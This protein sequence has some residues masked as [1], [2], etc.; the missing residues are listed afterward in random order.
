MYNGCGGSN[1]YVRV[2]DGGRLNTNGSDAADFGN[3]DGKF[4][5][6]ANIDGGDGDDKDDGDAN[7]DEN[8][9]SDIGSDTKC[10]D[11]WSKVD[12]GKDIAVDDGNSK[13]DGGGDAYN[14]GKGGD[15]SDGEVMI[16]LMKIKMMVMMTMDV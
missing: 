7:D 12:C 10:G 15:D 1:D 3:E 8:G 4:D 2:H 14:D 9:G 6:G 16:V 11:G 13:L 5:W